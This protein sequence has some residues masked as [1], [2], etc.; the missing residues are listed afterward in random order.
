MADLARGTELGQYK[1]PGRLAAGGMATVYRGYHDALDRVVA[2]KV[3]P[4]HS[5][6][7]EEFLGRFRQEAKTV[8]RLRHSNILEVY[9]FGEGG[10][11]I[12]YI[13]NEYMGGGTL[14]ARLGPPVDP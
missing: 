14:S 12:F 7:D 1:V 8:A 4:A 11:G 6:Q 3:L 10:D 5:A 13:V 9:D 2:I